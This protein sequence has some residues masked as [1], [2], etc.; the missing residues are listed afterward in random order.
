MILLQHKA[1][2]RFLSSTNDEVGCRE[3]IRAREWCIVGDELPQDA[4]IP[5]NKSFHIMHVPSKKYLCSSDNHAKIS[6]S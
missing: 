5:K 1:T 2:G 3:G 4:V 6:T